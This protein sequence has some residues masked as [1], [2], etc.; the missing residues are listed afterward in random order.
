VPLDGSP[1]AEQVLGPVSA[2]ARL[3]GA[4]LALVQ[5]VQPVTIV[6][7]PAL[8]VPTAYD[9]ELTQD[10]R[11]QAQDY[12]DGV[13]GRLKEEGIRA[14]AEACIGW[15]PVQT[16][17][18]WR[19]R[20][21]CGWSPSPPMAAAACSRWPRQRGGQLVRAGSGAVHRPAAAGRK[22]SAH[23]RGRRDDGGGRSHD[24]VW[25]P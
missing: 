9:E 24:A 13:A 10:W 17:W 22:R 11:R 3:W 19:V 6:D 1:L 7:E 21:A 15:S 5:V 4:E 8:P 12:L 20:S 14:T 25:G 18:I 16:L 2:L 23:R